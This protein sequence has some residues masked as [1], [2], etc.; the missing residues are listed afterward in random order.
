M[1]RGSACRSGAGGRACQRFNEAPIH[2][3][4][5]WRGSKRSR[6]PVARFNEAPIHES[7]KYRPKRER[8]LRVR[9]LQ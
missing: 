5:K 6:R 8:T 3:S 9:P 2:E 1:N 7:G 4:G